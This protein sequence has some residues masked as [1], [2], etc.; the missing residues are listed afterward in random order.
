MCYNDS[1]FG[2]EVLFRLPENGKGTQLM[3]R[4]ITAVLLS[5]LL[6]LS[7][8]GCADRQESGEWKKRQASFLNL[9]DTVTIVVGYAPDEEAFEQEVQVIHDLLQEYHELYD[10]YNDYPDLNNIKT[11]NDNAGIAPVEVDRR[12]LD[13]LLF[14][15]QAYEISDGTVNVAM[16]SV[17][18]IWHQYREAG[19]EDPE[20]AQLPP[21]QALQEAAK[22]TDIEQMVID[23][24]AGTV[25][26]ADPQMRLDV[27]A[28]AKGYAVQQVTAELLEQGISRYLISVGGNVSAIGPKGEAGEP[29]SVGIQSPYDPDSYDYTVQ[30]ASGCVV[31]SGN[32]QRSYTVDGQSYHHIIDPGTLY[33]AAHFDSVSVICGDS[34]LADALSTALYVMPYEEGKA[35]VES[36]EDV[37]ALWIVDE[38]TTLFSSGF[39]QLLR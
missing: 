25:Y 28:I 21:Q 30:I 5:L 32:Y 10:I 27:G 4:K 15:R 31:T 12:I 9:F 7:L 24:Q 35:L 17:L 16:G 14:A 20:N 18:E 1:G 39:E 2:G 22:H 11:I 36:L 34:G 29:W 3:R 8:A 6:C 19:I 38:E 37:Q 26:L 13:L 23:E 33:P